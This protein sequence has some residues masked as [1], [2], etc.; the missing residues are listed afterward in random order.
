MPQLG[1]TAVI[2]AV[3]GFQGFDIELSQVGIMEGS[4]EAFT[5]A[6]RVAYLV[7]ICVLC[8]AIFTASRT[9]SIPSKT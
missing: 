2:A 6:W 8:L 4:V 3:L 9:R 7:I 1:A 5:Y